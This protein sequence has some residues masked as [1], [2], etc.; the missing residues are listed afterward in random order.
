M[1][2][3]QDVNFIIQNFNYSDI[4]RVQLIFAPHWLNEY[5]NSFIQLNI[6]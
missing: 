5:H 3:V 4:Y 6:Y 2:V 1:F